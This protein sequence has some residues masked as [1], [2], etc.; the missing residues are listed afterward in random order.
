MISKDMVPCF[1]VLKNGS[2]IAVEEYY[3]GRFPF[4]SHNGNFCW[5]EDGKI[6]DHRASRFDIE[7]I[8]IPNELE[9]KKIE[10]LWRK[11]QPKWRLENAKQ[12]PG[13]F[14]RPHGSGSENQ[15]NTF[16]DKGC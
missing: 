10:L 1:A 9:R 15:S 2:K 6:N 14:I 16:R 7:K 13:D 11:E 5:N 12:K 4:Q 3:G 8:I